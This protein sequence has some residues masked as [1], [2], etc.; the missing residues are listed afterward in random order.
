MSLS[1]FS[2]VVAI[3]SDTFT[4]SVRP[5]VENPGFAVCTRLYFLTKELFCNCEY[6]V[7]QCINH[8]YRTTYLRRSIM[9]NPDKTDKGRKSTKTTFPLFCYRPNRL[10]DY[11]DTSATLHATCKP[12]WNSGPWHTDL[13]AVVRESVSWQEIAMQFGKKFII[14]SLRWLLATHSR[15][16]RS[17]PQQVAACCYIKFFSQLPNYVHE[18][19]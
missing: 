2:V 6:Y 15:W 18:S 19:W 7:S 4:E 3:I 9:S 17:C 5:M 14:D 13:V 1:P 8:H 11:T 12:T 16:A 10:K